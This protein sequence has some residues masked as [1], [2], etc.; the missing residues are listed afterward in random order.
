MVP[1]R[2]QLSLLS[3]ALALVQPTLCEGGPG[4]LASNEAAALGVPMLLSDIAVNRE[5][6]EPGVRFFRAGDAQDLAQ[7][8][9]E[10]LAAGPVTAVDPLEM[11]Q[12][13]QQ[14]RAACGR[15]LLQAIELARA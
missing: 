1:K 12:R 4:G 15:A 7:A 2:E 10:R 14:R 9:Q 3:G 13:G 8:L 5:V 11:A 6:D